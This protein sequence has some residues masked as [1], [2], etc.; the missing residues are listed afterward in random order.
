M[1]FFFFLT[2]DRTAISTACTCVGPDTQTG[3]GGATNENPVW[4]GQSNYTQ[5]PLQPQL[6]LATHQVYNLGTFHNS[7]FNPA[8]SYGVNDFAIL[9]D[10]PIIDPRLAAFDQA[11]ALNELRTAIVSQTAALNALIAALPNQVIA[12]NAPATTLG[13]STS[14]PINQDGTPSTPASSSNSTR[15]RLRCDLCDQTFARPYTLQRHINTQ[16][17]RSQVYPC[18][19]CGQNFLRSDRLNEHQQRYH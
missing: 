11:D 4:A 3:N 13:S 10:P 2:R 18:P 9:N 8:G 6:G 5:L 17:H 19:T 1:S 14:T 7:G 16:H 15:A 12:S